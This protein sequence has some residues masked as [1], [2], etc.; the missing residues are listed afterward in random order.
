MPQSAQ[1]NIDPQ[2]WDR[3]RKALEYHMDSTALTQRDLATRLG[4]DPTT[5]NNFLNRQ[6]KTLGGLAVA[7]AC[8]LLDLTCDGTKI[9]RIGDRD[10]AK[11]L[12]EPPP[13]QLILEFDEAFEFKPESKRATIVLRKSLA[14]QSSLRLSIRK[15]G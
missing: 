6:S 13:Q 12:M 11:P 1:T 7:L 5:L 2:F 15:I 3:L 9:G 10:H 4:L 14:R 8:T